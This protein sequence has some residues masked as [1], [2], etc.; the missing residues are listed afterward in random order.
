MQEL[1]NRGITIKKKRSCA[2][3]FMLNIN[4]IKEFTNL[5]FQY[6]WFHTYH[7]EAIDNLYLFN[8]E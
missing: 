6:I 5:Y 2:P 7:L 1:Y 8:V 3:I 4:H